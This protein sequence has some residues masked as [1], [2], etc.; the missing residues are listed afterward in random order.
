M[1]Y[2]YHMTPRKNRESILKHGLTVDNPAS[3]YGG[4][5]EHKAVY[6]YHQN[7]INVFYDMVAKFRDVDVWQIINSL[8]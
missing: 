8:L 1:H 2:L 6:L 7:N 5:P 4:I 3:G